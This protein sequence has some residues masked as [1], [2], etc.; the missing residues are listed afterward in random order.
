MPVLF[1]ASRRVR[2]RNRRQNVMQFEFFSFQWW[3]WH[4]KCLDFQLG[5]CSDV[6]M[7]THIEAV[8]R[9]KKSRRGAWVYESPLIRFAHNVPEADLIDAIN[10]RRS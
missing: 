5:R 9:A 7:L 2:A 3:G 10:E 6:Q 1:D 8:G 4:K